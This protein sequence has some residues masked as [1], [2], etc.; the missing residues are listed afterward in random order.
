[1]S[2]KYHHLTYELGYQICILKDRG[3]S[4]AAISRALNVH[5]STIS[6]EFKRNSS[7]SNYCYKKAQEMATKRKNTKPNKKM[8]ATLISTIHEKL[9]NQWSP[10]QISGWMQTQ[11]KEHVSYK[12][13]YNYIA[14]DTKL[15]G[16]LRKQ[17]RH[18]GKKY[19][20]QSKGNSGRGCIPNRIDI[21]QRPPIVDQKIRLGDWELDTIIGAGHKGVI[22]SM[23]ERVSKLT[24]IVKVSRKTA[25][26]VAQAIVDQL[27]PYKAFVHTLTSDNGKEFAF[28]QK[29]S[30]ELSA[31]F[32][33]ATPNHSWER[34]LNEHTNGLIRQYFPKSQCF[35]T[36]TSEDI[37]RVENLLNSRPRKVLGFATPQETFDKLSSSMLSLGA[38]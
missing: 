29:I 26:E 20:K 24:K 25:D 17:L 7:K 4:Y 14:K 37:L 19:N 38:Q 12:T 27:K 16:S 32:Y 8:T 11:E 2:K 34:G 28:H 1:M 9:K 31:D 21:D 35:T 15:N 33:F 10:V 18:N 13:I 36:L 30:L 22:V 23:V 3:S 6:R 5:Q